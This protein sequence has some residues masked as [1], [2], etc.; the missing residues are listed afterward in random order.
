MCRL[1]RCC[2]AFDSQAKVVKWTVLLASRILDRASNESRP[3]RQPD[4]LRHDFRRVTKPFFQIRRHRQI[5]RIYNQ[6]STSQ[7]FLSRQSAVS[8]PK[9][10][11][12]GSARCGQ[13]MEAKACENAGRADIPWIRNY[14][15][16]G[17]FVERSETNCFFVLG[18]THG[19]TLLSKSLLCCFLS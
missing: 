4:R 3:C 16:A 19:S 18:N 5:C 11:G 17:A 6:T 2:N 13:C 14:E 10:S 9:G 1:R 7:G 8:S 15:D 12:R